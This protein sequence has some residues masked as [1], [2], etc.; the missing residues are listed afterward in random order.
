MAYKYSYQ[1]SLENAARAVIVEGPFSTKQAIE[2]CAKLRNRSVT[3]AK[4]FLSEVKEE[5]R[6]VAYTRF[7]DGAGH[8]TGIGPGKFPVKTST[9]L[10]KLIESA[11]SNATDKGLGSSLKIV[12][13]SAQRASTP[14]HMGRQRRRAM[15]RTHVE[16]VVQEIIKTKS[17]K[18]TVTPKAKPLNE[19][20]PKKQ[21]PKKA[22]ETETETKPV[23]KEEVKVETKTES[24]AEVKETT[25]T[26]Q[27]KVD[28]K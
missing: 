11:E 20:T 9:Y 17:S 21:E 26:A 22:V 23:V 12:H 19:S 24:K 16:L 27:P 25:E 8:K 7:T 15:K 4:R 6:A 18:A 28:T 5:T 14:W 3:F 1:G 2:V 10:L 13:I